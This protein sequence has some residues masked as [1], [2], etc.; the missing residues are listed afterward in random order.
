MD[1]Q[2]SDALW[3]I[4]RGPAAIIRRGDWIDRA[5]LATPVDYTL[6]GLGLSDALEREGRTARAQGIRK[7]LLSVITAAR[8]ERFFGIPS[9]P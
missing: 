8:M 3:R 2:R 1:V 5:S 7:Q 4:Y 6:V 9:T